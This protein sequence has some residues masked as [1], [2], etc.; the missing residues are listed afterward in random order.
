MGW[1]TDVVAWVRIRTGAGPRPDPPAPSPPAP[2]QPG[3]PASVDAVIARMRQIDG[4]L[5]P[6]DGVG[7]FN[8]MY[9]RVTE[10]VRDRLVAGYFTDPAFVT[11]L[12]LVFAGLYLD[13]VDAA[14]PDPSWA[15]LFASRRE[16]GRVPIQFALAGMNAHINHDLP[17]AVVTTCRQL[18]LTPD[19][20]GVEDDYRRV[21][22]LLAAV[23]EEVRRSFLDGVALAV[24]RQ[25]AGP[26]ADLVSGW[27]ITRARD[28]AWTNARVLWSLDGAEPLRTEFLATL[29]R[30]VG[31]A[32]RY[33]LT[34]VAD[35]APEAPGSGPR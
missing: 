23:Q 3:Q 9:L 13:A 1:F 2:G 31:M 15:P 35:L 25:L 24:D 14:A 29:S 4:S 26:V 6:D 30:T 16:P 33:L 22:E 17:V 19:S 8:R 5:T 32:G 12:D 7:D 11:R 21:N 18:G 28:A 20:P 34:P 10:L 27:S